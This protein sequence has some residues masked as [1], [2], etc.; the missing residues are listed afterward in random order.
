MI[1]IRL[2][3]A[4][5]ALVACASAAA[6]PQP[7]ARGD[8]LP[9]RAVERTLPNGLKVIVVPTGFPN[10]VSLQIPVQTGS[11]NEVEPGKTGFAHFFEHMMFR[12]TKTTPP[13]EYQAVITRI[14]ARQN[15]YT[16][17]DLTNYHTTF[18]KQDL[19]EMLRLEADRFMNLDYSVEGFK[20]EARTILGEYTKNSANPLVKLDEVQANAAFTRHTYKHTTM[21]F[22]E[23]IERM[24]EQ[25]DYSRQF[26]DRWY[27][28]EY[29][30]IVV[31]GDVDPA[32]VI[33]LVEKHFGS[34]K[35]GKHVVEIPQEPPPKSAVYAHVPWTTP[36]LPWVTVAFHAPPFS[37]REKGW[38][39]LST[40]LS[41]R[42]GET[43]DLYKRLVQDE[44]KVDD[45]FYDDGQ[46]KD[47]GLVTVYARLK[48]A[49]DAVVV[50]DAILA[51]FAKS[52]AETVDAKRLADEKSNARYGFQRRLDNT[53]AIA[54]IV[55]RFAHFERSYRTV[56]DLFR[57]VDT[58]GPQDLLAAAR[59]WF[60]DEGLVVTTLSKEPLPAGIDKA[61]ALASFEPKP[62]DTADLPVLVQKSP[63][64]QINV[65]LL[66]EAGSARDP[67][68]KE[69][70]A[71]L[72]ADMIADAGSRA[73][74]VDEIQKA[75]HPIA[76]SFEAR[77]DK[78]MVTFTGRFPKDGWERFFEVALPQL[79]DPGF[80]DEDFQ[81]VKDA[82][83]TALVQD[84]RSNNDEELGKER[85]QANVF[86][87]SRYGHPVQGTVAGLDAI[88][89][90]DVRAFARA[91]YVR[92]NLT[93]GVAGDAPD[94]LV[95]R[96]KRE[97][98]K[99]PLGAR[100]AP[101][102]VAAK[103]PVGIEVEIVEK[104]TRGTAISFGHPIEVRRG[105]PD[106]VALWL[107]R[108][109]LGEHRSSMSHLYERI[110]EQRGMNYGDYA[111]VEAFP[112][113]MF[114]F[115]P[116]PNLGRRAQL[117]EVWIRPV[118]PPNAHMAIRLALDSLRRLHAEGLS[119]EDF[120]ATRA[121]LSK[122]VFVMTATQDQQLGYALDSR[123]YGIPEFTKY[124]R[125]GLAKLT[126][127]DV[128]RAIRTHLDP[129]N[130]SFV[131]I[132]KDAKGLAEQL[133]ADGVSTVKY[134]SEKPK[135]LLE[136]DARVGAMKLGVR[137]D[138]VKIT[139]VEAV[140]AK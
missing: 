83:R 43:S 107:A 132:T 9:F 121:Y 134:E 39:A 115:F 112:R 59:T 49:E 25:Y 80:R 13:A 2:A 74:R 24:P 76:G 124:V 92:A 3:T 73:M 140:F 68:G 139:P 1:R 60:R 23:D 47:A 7:A 21:G 35:R 8:V 119:R 110:R 102:A 89:L 54:S 133:V 103:R 32:K 6:A 82:R 53:E 70:L 96:L 63:L 101:T 41:I 84:L 42:F 91:H 87:G 4:L 46:T 12:G 125:D 67:E 28:P 88:T 62:A 97:V 71:A 61:P 36:T 81:R 104:D 108:A 137:R 26:F 75:L 22:L 131:V 109:W 15:A 50:R 128:N 136:E 29:A 116:D 40:L 27:R 129:A 18:A 30:T 45:L 126:V 79:T 90:D 118:Q 44:Q 85:L 51:E 5:A 37:P 20:T 38:A 122:N 66:F 16:S 130:L 34:W 99:L 52:R 86:A 135:A 94:A 69:G 19:E 98:G 114:Q 111:Y 120:E 113:G 33:P 78:E 14:G 95:A 56:N 117:F 127:E 64:P 31:A 105:H 72:T 123:W 17:L 11:R 65:K 100:P 106:F 77:V 138:A 58:L 57:V 55:A 10:I 48:K 93:V